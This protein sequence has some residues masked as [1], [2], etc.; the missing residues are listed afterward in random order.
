[1][2][3]AQVVLSQNEINNLEQAIAELPVAGERYTEEGM[4]GLNA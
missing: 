2:A 1:M 4:K 3:A